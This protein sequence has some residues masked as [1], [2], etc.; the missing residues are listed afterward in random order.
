MA[1]KQHQPQPLK[2]TSL[3][4]DFVLHQTSGTVVPLPK[5]TV[6]P[7]FKDA[8]L[9]LSSAK[10]AFFARLYMTTSPPQV[11]SQLSQYASME[12]LN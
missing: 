3:S 4:A 2:I 1:K 7:G 6:F 10:L 8:S 9:V 11:R 12:D 5:V